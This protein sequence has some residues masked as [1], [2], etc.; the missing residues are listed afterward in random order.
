MS[1]PK[2]QNGNAPLSHTSSLSPA[3]WWTL[4]KIGKDAFARVSMK[5][6]DSSLIIVG[7]F[8]F[9]TYYYIELEGF[10]VTLPLVF[11]GVLPDWGPWTF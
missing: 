2:T 7:R 9:N 3:S 4:K 5:G 1:V 11:W 8:D 10:R 6:A